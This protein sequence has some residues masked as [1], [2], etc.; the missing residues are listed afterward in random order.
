M[1]RR[2]GIDRRKEDEHSIATNNATRAWKRKWLCVAFVCSFCVRLAHSTDLYL[3]TTVPAGTRSSSTLLKHFFRHYIDLGIPPSHFLVVV[4]GLSEDAVNEKVKEVKEYGVVYTRRW[5]GEFNSNRKRAEYFLLHADAK[6][7][8]HSQWVVQVDSD[9]LLMSSST[10]E[11]LVQFLKAYRRKGYQACFADRV[12]RDGSIPLHVP[13]TYREFLDSF[14]LVCPITRMFLTRKYIRK[15]V[16]FP[17]TY[18]SAS[19]FFI[20]H[21]CVRSL[22][23]TDEEYNHA[24]RGLAHHRRARVFKDGCDYPNGKTFVHHFKWQGSLRDDLAER[25]ASFRHANIS[26]YR[27]SYKFVKLLNKKKKI[28][29]TRCQLLDGTPLG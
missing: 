29:L 21:L 19:H 22:F 8:S 27:Q 3:L 9:E 13:S 15:M 14:P 16:L 7:Q 12:T 28:P 23:S 10:L 11:E 26:W 17:A 1:E 2:A 18:R 24:C 20:N 4:Q 25:A 6:V 5:I